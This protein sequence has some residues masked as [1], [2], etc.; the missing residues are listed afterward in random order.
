MW[1]QCL[2][3][4]HQDVYETFIKTGM[5][6]SFNLASH[7]KSAARFG[8]NEVIYDTANDL[9]YKPFWTGDTLKISE[10]RLQGKDTIHK[11]TEKVSYIIG[12]GQHTNSHMINV[13]G[14]VYQAPF[15]FYTQRG[16]WDL[17]PG[18]EHNNV[19]FKRPIGLECMSCH[20]AYPSL[21][22]VRKISF[23]KYLPALIVSD[24]MAQ[25]PFMY[26]KNQPV[27]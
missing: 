9:H 24:A 15:T 6:Q 5:G 14:Y 27:I 20:N 7:Q 18:F 16:V 11:R 22:R 23:P 13:N 21:L 25:V 2:Q 3:T 10:Y 1:H 8:K 26:G 12:S 17:P 19:G 4:C